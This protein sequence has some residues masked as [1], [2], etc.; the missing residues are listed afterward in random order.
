MLYHLRKAS[1]VPSQ[2]LKL[3]APTSPGGFTRHIPTYTR[4]N[5]TICC[6]QTTEYWCPSWRYGKYVGR[7]LATFHCILTNASLQVPLVVKIDACRRR[8]GHEHHP[9]PIPFT[10][11]YH[12]GSCVQGPVSASRYPGGEGLP[13]TGHCAPSLEAGKAAGLFTGSVVDS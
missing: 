9:P 6:G 3:S 8:S 12:H 11:G 13:R 10:R 7:R 5:L 4:R 2:A 1:A